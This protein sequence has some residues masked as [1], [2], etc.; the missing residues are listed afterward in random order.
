M[1]QAN[2]NRYGVKPVF[3]AFRTLE[4]LARAGG[5]LSIADLAARTNASRTTT[6]RY[7]KTLAMLGYA[8]MTNSGFY[9]IGHAASA[10]ARSAGSDRALLVISE[11]QVEALSS[12][13]GETVN[14]AV[15]NGKRLRY[16]KIKE[17]SKP[18]R[19]RAEEGDS[20]CFHCTA[21]GKAILAHIPSEV[22][23][24]HLNAELLRFTDRTLVTRRALDVSLAEI[25]RFGYAIDNEENEVGCVCYAAPIFS[26]NGQPMAAISVSVP[27]PRLTD[28]LSLEIPQAVVEA[29]TAIT[30]RLGTASSEGPGKSR[31][32][33]GSIQMRAR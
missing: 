12:R 19:F 2:P 16:I 30:R 33:K 20:E 22:I 29:A 31:R 9:E 27:T 7:L 15:P 5:P 4:E 1:V 21:V 13:F 17:T 26:A 28:R 8:E 25:R 18:L 3:A 11:G 24:D 10:L 14:V 6:F 23:P 32:G